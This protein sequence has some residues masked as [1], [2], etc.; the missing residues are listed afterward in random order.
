VK[1]AKE[2]ITIQQKIKKLILKSLRLKSIV[3]G[4]INT[5]NIK[6]QNFNVGISPLI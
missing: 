5:L 3:N 1:S 6:K 2:E 4:A